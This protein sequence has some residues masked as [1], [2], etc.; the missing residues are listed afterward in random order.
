DD[1][2]VTLDLSSYHYVTRIEV[3]NHDTAGFLWDNFS[4]TPLV[5]DADVDS[6]NDNGTAAPGRTDDEDRIEGD[7]DFPGKTV[8]LNVADPD[9][10][11]IPGYA[12]GFNWDG[13]SGTD[14]QKQDDSA[15]ATDLVPVVVEV[16]SDVDLS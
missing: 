12:D 14:Q 1:R 8:A 15:P 7:V 4:F 5:V 16:P 11:L 9:G 3:T 10:D 13:Q 6:D 2:P